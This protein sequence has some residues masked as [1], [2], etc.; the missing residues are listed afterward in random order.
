MI[1]LRFTFYKY[2]IY[3]CI[4]KAK[5][6]IKRH[7]KR[8]LNKKTFLTHKLHEKGFFIESL[9]IKFLFKIIKW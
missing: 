3:A 6:L 8:R 4:C 2:I 7:I 9:G 5:N 1:L